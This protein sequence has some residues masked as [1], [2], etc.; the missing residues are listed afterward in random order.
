[1]AL[2]ISGVLI[3][4]L[5]QET[6]QGKNGPWVKQNFIIE[7]QE[8]INRKICVSAWGDKA[9]SVNQFAIGTFLKIAINIES[10]EFNGRWYT[11]VRAW[12]IETVTAGAVPTPAAAPMPNSVP[13]QEFTPQSAVAETDVNFTAT[14]EMED[15]LP[16]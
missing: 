3:Q 2:E 14:N 9:D 11:D 16:F 5:P 8:Q 10:R 6:G 15:D 4:K 1:M 7:T 13:T 12:K